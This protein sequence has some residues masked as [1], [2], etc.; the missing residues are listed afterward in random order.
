M[1]R[2]VHRE[3]VYD[4]QHIHVLWVGIE[5]AEKSAHH[6]ALVNRVLAPDLGHVLEVL[7]LRDH[8][9]VPRP[10]LGAN[11]AQHLRMVLADRGVHAHDGALSTHDKKV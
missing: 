1:A 5:H 2:E 6:E 8:L 11:G 10:V 9:P 7:S 4:A 3:L